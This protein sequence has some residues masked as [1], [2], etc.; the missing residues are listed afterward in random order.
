M[1]AIRLILL[2][3]AFPALALAHGGEDHSH[4]EASAAQAFVSGQP[5]IETATETFEI[6]GQLKG[7]E[8]SLLIDRF[9]TNEPV[10]NG[11]VEVEL[12]GAKAQAKFHPDHG[13]YVVDD[14]ALL[15]ALGKPGR[16]SL[17]FTVSAGDETDLLEGALQVADEAQAGSGTPPGRFPL[18]TV[19]IAGL[20]LAFVLAAMAIALA[21]RK[22]SVGS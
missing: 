15:D 10:L 18:S 11:T 22:S 2:S 20:V 16:H 5:R 4:D 21:R 12:N 6:V 14:K 8:L 17:A 9:A 1:K 7:G 3:L 19:A 13:D